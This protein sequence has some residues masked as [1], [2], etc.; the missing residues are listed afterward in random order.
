MF[1]TSLYCFKGDSIMNIYDFITEKDMLSTFT[2][3]VGLG[4]DTPKDIIVPEQVDPAVLS[5]HLT[6]NILDSDIM[7]TISEDA[8]DSLNVPKIR[9]VDFKNKTQWLE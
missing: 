6:D 5:A 3:A 7:F 4:I 2:I 8:W 9:R 1:L